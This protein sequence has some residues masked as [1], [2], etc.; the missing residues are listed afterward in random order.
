M[1]RR[2]RLPT[3]ALLLL[4]GWGASPVR[5][6]EV[7]DGVAAVVNN[8]VITF[9]QVRD[10]VGPKEKQIRESLKGEALMEKIKEIRL[11]AVNELI[12][13]QL[14]LQEF[15]EM[16]KKGANIPPHVIDEHVETI[17]REQ[18]SGDKSAFIR[19]LQAQGFT[20]ERFRQLEEEKVIVQAMRGQ[21]IKGSTIVSEAKIRAYYQEHIAEFT[22]AEQLKL[23]MLVM[24]KG[25]GE[26][27]GRLK[28]MQELREKIVGGA[29]F[30]DLARMYDESSNQDQGGDWG[31]INRKTLN[32]ALTKAA[33]SLKPGEI[34]KILDLYGNYYLL[35]C[36]AK[37]SATTKPYAELRE[38]IEKKLI[39]EERQ[40]QQEEWLAK[41][42]KKAFVKIY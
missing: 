33:F 42:R 3:I 7:L 9:S 41:L 28:M 15:A 26:G 20:L 10:L 38:T 23:R 40:K 5:A 14:I 18:F 32:E 17:V 34:S 13:R 1:F 37:K 39:Q 30:H 19:T 31:W 36:E 25:G 24:K 27:D 11:A 12:N 6:Q 21:Q 16:K 8:E 4:V 22:D 35:Y 29:Q 2:L